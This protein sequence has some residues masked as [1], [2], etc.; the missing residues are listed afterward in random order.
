MTIDVLPR[1]ET[2]G[3]VRLSHD[4]IRVGT[5]AAGETLYKKLGKRTANI[6]QRCDS[7]LAQRS[8]TRKDE[9][10]VTRPFSC[11]GH[12]LPYC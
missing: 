8:K 4:V 12:G 3:Q 11:F 10:C 9:P 7:L 1:T 2:G 5:S 6:K